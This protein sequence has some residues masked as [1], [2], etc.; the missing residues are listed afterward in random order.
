MGGVRDD[1]SAGSLSA[2]AH[3]ASA[4]VPATIQYTVD[5]RTPH[6]RSTCWLADHP[7]PSESDTSH[8]KSS[9]T[10]PFQI[11][12]VTKNVKRTTDCRCRIADPRKHRVDERQPGVALT[13]STVNTTPS[14]RR[15]PSGSDG[16]PTAHQPG[17]LIE[18]APTAISRTGARP[19]RLP[20]IGGDTFATVRPYRWPGVHT[21]DA[22]LF[23]DEV[24]A[25][26]AHPLVVHTPP[27]PPRVRRP[28][29]RNRSN[30]VPCFPG[31]G[32]LPLCPAR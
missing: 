30:E 18:L 27:A 23:T 5:A 29:T 10:T 22:V 11:L 28:W 19:R 13:A 20:A 24:R 14:E 25:H 31:P 21:Q 32:D 4:T 12:A 6:H 1:S 3:P 2:V 8:T 26:S 7:E 9:Q 17:Q 15:Y 16:L